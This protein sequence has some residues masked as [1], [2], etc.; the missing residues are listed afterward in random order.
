[1]LFAVGAVSGTV[2]SFEMGTLWPHFMA[3]F[4]QVFGAAFAM[5]G[6]AFFIEAIFIGIY[7]YGWD[8]LSPRA[9]L[10]TGLPI[11][12]GGVAVGVLRRHRQLLDEPAARLPR[13]TPR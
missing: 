1:M 4:G 6:I 11:V 2:L 7:L 10:L 5:E 9:H 8:R 13:S 3:K 12:V